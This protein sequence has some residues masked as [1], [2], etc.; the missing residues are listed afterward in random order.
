MT[1]SV[2]PK[3]CSSL[4]TVSA[5]IA[6]VDFIKRRDNIEQVLEDGT[7]SFLA[8]ASIRHGFKI[9]NTLTHSAISRYVFNQPQ[10]RHSYTLILTVNV[11]LGICSSGR[12]M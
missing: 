5:S 2:Q 8:I 1:I 7:I 12:K 3:I 6:D 10:S 11:W 9:I 4:G